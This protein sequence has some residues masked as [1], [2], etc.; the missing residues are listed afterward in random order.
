MTEGCY[1]ST[2]CSPINAAEDAQN[3]NFPQSSV[4]YGQGDISAGET[5]LQHLPSRFSCLK[6]GRK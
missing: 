1:P 3:I 6:D 2:T 5:H 4:H